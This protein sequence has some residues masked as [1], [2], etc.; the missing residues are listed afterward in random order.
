MSSFA[1]VPEIYKKPTEDKEKPVNIVIPYPGRVVVWEDKFKYSGAIII[2][3][4]S[5]SKPTIGRVIAVGK[6]VPDHIQ[7][8]KRVIFPMYSG[9]AYYFKG[10]SRIR[11]LTPEEIHG[12]VVEGAENVEL[13]DS[14]A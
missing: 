14:G 3:K 10:C 9:T 11:V 7:V 1:T 5:E 8:G 13:E 2:P 6:D 12:E 4:A